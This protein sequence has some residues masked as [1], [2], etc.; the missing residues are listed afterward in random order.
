[1]S[2]PVNVFNLSKY[3]IKGYVAYVDDDKYQSQSTMNWRDPEFINT[4]PSFGHKQR[5]VSI[6]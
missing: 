1:M 6:Q 2:A 3:T 4:N 5:N